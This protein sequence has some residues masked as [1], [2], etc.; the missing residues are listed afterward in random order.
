MKFL[1][2][3][4]GGVFAL[5]GAFGAAIA[6]ENNF[7][8]FLSDPY[9]VS[10]YAPFL[11][12]LVAGLGAAAAFRQ[13]TVQAETKADLE[14][15]ARDAAKG[16]EASVEAGS[17]LRGEG[18]A[19]RVTVRNESEKLQSGQ[20]G[21]EAKIDELLAFERAKAASE[22]RDFGPDA[23]KTFEKHVRA[24]L[25]SKD[26]RKR[27][28]QE[29]LEENRSQDAAD[30]LIKVTAH[31]GAAAVDFVR[32]AAETYR[33]AASLYYCVQ[34]QK[35]LEAY[36]EATKLDASDFNSWIYLARLEDRQAGNVEASIKAAQNAR[37]VAENHRDASIASAQ[38]AEGLLKIGD[39]AAA[40]SSL[41]GASENM[42]KFAEA[43]PSSAEAQRDVSV[44]LEKIGDVAVQAGDFGT[45]R[46]AF[47][48]SHEIR[49]KIAVK[50]P[51]SFGA[52][53]DVSVSL[54]RLGDVELRAG[55]LGAA[56]TAYEEC[57][58]THRALAAENADSSGAQ[59]DVSISLQK[60]GDVELQAGNLGASRTAVTESLEI[61]RRLAAANPGSA[62]A[63]RDYS[64][65][66]NRFGKV[67][68]Q[69][70]NFDAALTAFDESL[71]ITRRLAAANTGSAE[72]Q[73]DLILSLARLAQI[74]GEVGYWQEAL[75][76]VEKLAAEGRL[77]APDAWMLEDIRGNAA[78][79]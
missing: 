57:V 71:G 33:E 45:A 16:R 56:R 79:E 35:A 27:P 66:L 70:G 68:L 20:A 60:L 65:S 73:R 31:E 53:R 25:T 63:L 47:E 1:E 15:I 54:E 69:A 36:R 39:L 3:A 55:N 58:E 78:A 42:R 23:A 50:N 40:I 24:I 11:A 38:A 12:A 61:T 30:E 13:L 26:A 76:I 74:T 41:R 28:A 17:A 9:S 44:M 5:A 67:E 19:T 46:A 29:A 37:Q 49:L 72:A 4:V 2:V 62:E 34:P 21:R 75:P 43:N 52:Q 59:R 7:L 22:G 14:Q 51:G 32:E 48:E 6:T 77:A 10:S 18:A 8:A 64:I